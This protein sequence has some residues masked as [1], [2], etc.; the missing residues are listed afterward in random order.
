MP[1]PK[2]PHGH[3]GFLDIELAEAFVVESLTESGTWIDGNGYLAED[4][5][6]LEDGTYCCGHRGGGSP[7]W[8][9]CVTHLEDSFISLDGGGRPF[10][11]RLVAVSKPS[12]E[13]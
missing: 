10:R 1:G 12:K 11:Y 6:R 4:C 2:P 7:L 3:D 13:A 8:I 5:N 9:R